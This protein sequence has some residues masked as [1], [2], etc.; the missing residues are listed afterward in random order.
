[1][2]IRTWDF[3]QMMRVFLGTLGYGLFTKWRPSPSSILVYLNFK[4]E[5][6]KNGYG[7]FNLLCL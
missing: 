4:F 1:M 7:Y 6:V 2:W 5:N 3:E